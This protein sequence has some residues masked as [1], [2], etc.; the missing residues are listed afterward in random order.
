MFA[1]VHGCYNRGVIDFR[2]LGPLEVW[3]G[4]RPLALKRSKHRA[5]LAALLLPA[6]QVVS[7]DQLLDDL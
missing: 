2:V 7:V 5:L 3:D 4:G 1:P 6:G